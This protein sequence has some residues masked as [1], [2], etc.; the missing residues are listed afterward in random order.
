MRKVTLVRGARQLL[1]LR[2][3]NGPR[4]GADLQNLGLIQDGA[5]LIVDGLIHEVGPTRRLENLA[6]A[7]GAEEIDASGRVVMPAFVD[8]HIHAVSGPA[9]PQD[10]DLRQSAEAVLAIARAIQDYSPRALEAMALR[11]VEDAL[12]HGTT[13]FGV[14][15]G[16][17]LT[18]AGEMK[19]LR[20]HTALRR[21]P[22]SLAST[23]LSARVP[24]DYEARQDEYL[25]WI[26][27]RLLPL[28][29]RRG[30]AEFVEIRCG[31]G[32]FTLTQACSFLI[33][34]RRLGLL[35]KVHAGMGRNPGAITLAV[36]S[37]A[38]SIVPGAGTTEQE[39]RLLGESQTIAT[40]LPGPIFYLGKPCYPEARLLI[41]SGAAVA[42]ATDYNPDTSPSPSMQAMIA[43]ACRAM[44]MTPAEAIT[45]AT[46]NAAH[47]LRRAD[48]LGSLETGKSADLVILGVQ[49]YRELPGHFGVNVVDLVMKNGSVLVERSK[50]RWP[51]RSGGPDSPAIE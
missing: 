40:L 39:A 26:S 2:G 19:I 14:T 32:S 24:G 12:R 49:D 30:L 4:R 17:G 29:R 25:Q 1:T 9:R 3:P 15:S 10:D 38:V 36:Q 46:I 13:T 5:V 47:A 21:R 6:L 41:G 31:E 48:A 23:Y 42:L 37:G 18:V 45:A 43:L 51:A 16:F 28:L 11:V 33:A 44:R 8:A 7:R 50:V 34:G 20:V 22:I 27:V 35:L